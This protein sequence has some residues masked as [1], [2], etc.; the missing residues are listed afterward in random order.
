MLDARGDFI[1][2][3]LPNGMVL[4]AGGDDGDGAA[5]LYDPESGT[6]TATSPMIDTAISTEP[7]CCRMARSSSTGGATTFDEAD[8]LINLA[9]AE[10]YDPESWDLDRNRQDGNG[11]TATTPQ[12]CCPTA[13]C[14]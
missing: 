7:Q 1:A 5:E 8:E 14:S 6:S 13:R 9:S 12:R 3:P 10:L 2:A 4:V 11:P